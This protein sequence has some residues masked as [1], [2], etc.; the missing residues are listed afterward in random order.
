M[1]QPIDLELTVQVSADEWAYMKRRCDYLEALLLRVVRD[2]NA[3]Q[4][5]YSS[6]ELSGLSL[7]GLPRTAAAISRRANACNWLN[8]RVLRGNRKTRV[9]HVA[10]LPARSFDMLLSRILDMPDIAD[11]IEALPDLPPVPPMPRTAEPAQ[12]TAPPCVLPLM[13]LMRDNRDMGT[14]WAQ[15]PDCL[16]EGVELPPIEQAAETLIRLGLV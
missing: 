12:N 16:P 7:P 1:T 3:I 4:E 15:L 13:R 6:A 9:Y 14:A 2:R 5:W 8:K 10:S 11:A